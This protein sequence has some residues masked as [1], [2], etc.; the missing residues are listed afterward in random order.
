MIFKL[1]WCIFEI[2]IILDKSL[3]ENERHIL[4]LA[5]EIAAF[6]NDL[7]LWKRKIEEEHGNTDCFPVLKCVLKEKYNQNLGQVWN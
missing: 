5:D 4:Q 2:L 3:Q 6:Q 1:N 7:L